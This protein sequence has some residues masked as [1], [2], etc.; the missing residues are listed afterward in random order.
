M[1]KRTTDTVRVAGL[2]AAL[3]TGSVATLAVAPAYA[4]EEVVADT[5]AACSDAAS[6]LESNDIDAALEEASW[7]FEGMQQLKQQQTV[8]VFPDTVDGYVGGEVANSNALGM[9]LL[10]RDYEK[11]GNAITVELST[12]GVSGLG[13]QLTGLMTIFGGTI[14]GEGKKLRIQRR[15]V[16]D[17]SDSTSAN[18]VVTLKSG[19]LMTVSSTSVSGE[20]AVKFLREFPIEEL[21]DELAK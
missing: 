20:D 13:E 21:D 7:C 9:T 12:G 14:A 5:I 6:F 16:I 11:D 3:V 15:T 4:N 17:S 1:I 19:A 10:T 18:L 8:S 2:V